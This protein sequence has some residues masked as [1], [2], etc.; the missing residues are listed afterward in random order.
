[1]EAEEL[2]VEELRK[3]NQ[4]V[5]TLVEQ[6][7]RIQTV[8]TITGDEIVRC[9]EKLELSTRYYVPLDDLLGPGESVTFNIAPPE[10][11]YCIVA[12]GIIDTSLLY[13]TSCEVTFRDHAGV[14][15]SR[16]NFGRI[17]DTFCG[18]PIIFI[19]CQPRTLY[20]FKFT[21]NDPDMDAYVGV[22]QDCNVVRKEIYNVIAETTLAKVFDTLGE[23]GR[24]IGVYF[25]KTA[26]KI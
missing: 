3:I 15:F 4:K 25:G 23:T 13:E 24:V 2:L 22:W 1:M 6:G 7:E 12:E 8:I 5:Q 11:E 21:N 17:F 16:I 14:E 10:N 26:L 19:F 9:L 20:S 18:K